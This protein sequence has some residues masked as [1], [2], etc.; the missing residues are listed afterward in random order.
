MDVRYI[1]GTGERGNEIVDATVVLNPLPPS[2]NNNLQLALPGLLAGQ[3]QVPSVDKNSLVSIIREATTGSLVLDGLTLILPRDTDYRFQ[4]SVLDQNTSF[5]PQILQ[6]LGRSP[7]PLSQAAAIDDA[8]RSSNPPFDGIS[9]LC[10]WLGLRTPDP[11]S[12]SSITITLN[13]PVDIMVDRCSLKAGAL[14]LTLHAHPKA[15]LSLIG[16]AMRAVPG[17][18]LPSRLQIADR[19]VWGSATDGRLEGNVDIKLANA[20]GAQVMLMI[21]GA[22]VRRHWFLDPTKAATPRLAAV[23]HFDTDLRMI[24]QGLFDAHDSKRFELSVAA[25]LF[26]LGFAPSVQLETNSPDILVS[27][28]QGRLAVVECTTRVAD[29]MTKIGKLVDRRGGLTK[30]LEVEHHRADVVAALV[31]RL[32]KDQIAA[33]ST[34]IREMNVLLITAEDLEQALLRAPFPTDPDSIIAQAEQRLHDGSR[35]PLL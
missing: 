11:S 17:E 22:T 25:L 20:H 27:T 26:L 34:T 7:A 15:D 19:I 4:P 18:G 10:S 14:R 12:L 6:I 8:L 31:C 30:A 5:S 13:P 32:P 29:V 9:D 16:L 35:G 23:Q 24:R 2:A 3:W 28:P 33:Q 21:G 1:A